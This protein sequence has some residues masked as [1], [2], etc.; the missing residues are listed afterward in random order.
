MVEKKAAAPSKKRTYDFT[1]ETTVFETRAWGGGRACRWCAL[2]MVSGCSLC[3]CSA[4]PLPRPT[5]HPPAPL[6]AAPH[7]GDL[8]V[9]VAL[10]ITLLWLPLS[11]AAV[12]RGLFVTYRFT[13]R[14]ISCITSAPWQSERAV[15]WAWQGRS[16][17]AVPVCRRVWHH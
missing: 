10:G 4:W 14:R 13:D 8:A 15:G 2:C 7:R 9:N 5:L 3:W 1:G 17:G 11:I 12:G 6:P 16:A